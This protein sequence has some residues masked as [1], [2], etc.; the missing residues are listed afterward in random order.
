MKVAMRGDAFL[1]YILLSPNV[2]P[3]PHEI[4]SQYQ[5]F[6]DVFEK[7]NANTLPKYQPY[8]CAIDLVKGAQP[9][10]EP[11]YNLAQDELVT[12]CEYIDENLEKGFIQ[13]SKSPAGAPIMFIKNKDGSPR[14]CVDYC[15]FN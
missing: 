15:G 12:F 8:I 1:I 7:K 4:P 14:M 5:K 6:K 2:E 9:P 11:I 13:H 10:F 3:H